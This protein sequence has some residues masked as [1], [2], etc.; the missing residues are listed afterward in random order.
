MPREADIHRQQIF[1]M[2]DD[3][4]QSIPLLP[5]KVY[6]APSGYRLRM[7]KHPAAPSWRLIGTVGEGVL[8]HK[9]C[10]VSGGGKSE[11]S[12]SIRD[13]MH[14]GPI[15]VANIDEDMQLVEEIVARDYQGRWKVAPDYSDYS[16]RTVLSQRRSPG[17]VIKLLTPSPE[18]TDKYNEWLNSIPN[19][20]YAMVCVGLR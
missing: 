15:F 13:Y 12:K 7:E 5:G 20:V 6:M 18:Y 2:K 10:T 4:E 17:S 11:I 3:Q 19:H 1:W 8:C 14:F 9:P 16:T